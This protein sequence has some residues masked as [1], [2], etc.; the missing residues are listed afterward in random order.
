VTFQ[1]RLSQK[2]HTR[3]AHAALKR[4]S[5]DESLCST[6]G[7]EPAGCSLGFQALHGFDVTPSMASTSMLQDVM[8]R[9]STSTVQAPQ[10]PWSQRPER[11]CAR[12]FATAHRTA[13]AASPRER[14]ELASSVKQGICVTLT[15][16]SPGS[17]G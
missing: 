14:H 11:R 2:D 6:L 12:S 7:G 1:Q 10:T 15:T 13:R 5:F 3:R 4:V 9:P 16:R 17:D 8:G